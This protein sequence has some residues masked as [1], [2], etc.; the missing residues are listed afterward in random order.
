MFLFLILFGLLSVNPRIL[1][2]KV[3]TMPTGT[4]K[5]FNSR[6]GFG[7]ITPDEG[8]K[9]VFVH[10]SAIQ[11]EGNEFAVLNENDKV[12]FD[13][14]QGEKGL[15]AQNVVVTEKAPYQPRAR[16]PDFPARLPAQSHQGAAFLDQPGGHRRREAPPQDRGGI[17]EKIRQAGPRGLRA[18]RNFPVHQ[19]QPP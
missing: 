18:H 9:D 3:N 7:F 12:E 10:Y 2:K 16:H 1:E 5:W 6:K 8:E 11:A 14:N 4:V 15:E 13:V 17:R 19:R